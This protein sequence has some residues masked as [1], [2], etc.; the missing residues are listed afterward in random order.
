ML[1]DR[2]ADRGGGRC[3]PIEGCQVL[4]RLVLMSDVGSQGWSE[5]VVG[6][7]GSVGSVALCLKC[8]SGLLGVLMLGWDFGLSPDMGQLLMLCN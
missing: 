8:L 6:S 1:V 7:Q 4:L 2:L 5:C 3:H